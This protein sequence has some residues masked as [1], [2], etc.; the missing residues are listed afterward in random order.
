[1]SGQGI[2]ID[3]FLSRFVLNFKLIF[4]Q[5]QYPPGQ[6]GTLMIFDCN[7]LFKSRMVCHNFEFPTIEVTSMDLRT[8]Y[9][10]QKLLVCCT[11]IFLGLVQHSASKADR[12]FLAILK[13]I[14]YG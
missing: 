13:L 14:K 6:S 2:S 5:F 3:M 1:M 7:K 9:N 4:S 10:C 8:K 11:I 12:P